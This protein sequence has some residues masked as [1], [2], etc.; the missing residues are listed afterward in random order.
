MSI[1]TQQIST[2]IPGPISLTG[3]Q[4]ETSVSSG[5]HSQ[6]VYRC[7]R[8][9]AR[10]FRTPRDLALHILAK[11]GQSELSERMEGSTTSG[12]DDAR[13]VTFM[14]PLLD[15]QGVSNSVDRLLSA[16]RP[17]RDSLQVE[18]KQKAPRLHSASNVTKRARIAP[19]TTKR[20]RLLTHTASSDASANP[21]EPTSSVTPMRPSTRKRMPQ[22]LTDASVEHAQEGESIGPAAQDVYI[23]RCRTGRI[24]VIPKHS[25][26]TKTLNF[27]Q[28]LF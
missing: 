1:V 19:H 13:S 14:S 9:T 12:G 15:T 22:T 6:R 16:I 28:G 26:P 5:V 7:R 21:H 20:T 8:C 17:Q 23:K 11:H 3:A 4:T 18:R 27:A 2:T 24:P 10:K 25:Q